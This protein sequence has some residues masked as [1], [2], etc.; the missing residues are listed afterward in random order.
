MT[1][2]VKKILSHLKKRSLRALCRERNVAVPQ[3][4]RKLIKRLAR[5][6]HGDLVSILG[7]LRRSDLIAVAEAVS[8]KDEFDRPVV[9][10]HLRIRQFIEFLLCC[11]TSTAPASLVQT[12][13]DQAKFHSTGS[14]GDV[15]QLNADKLRA[16]AR[17]ACRATVISA[18][19]GCDV[20]KDLLDG[21][22]EVRVL[23]NGLGG[24]RLEE[25]IEELTNLEQELRNSKECAEIKLAFSRGIFHTKLYLFE[26]G[27]ES[28]SW[29]GSANATEAALGG[30]N[31]EILLRLAPAPRTLLDYA[32]CAWANGRTLKDSHPSIDSLTAFFRTGVLYYKPYSTLPMTENPFLPLLEALPHEE[33]R[34]LPQSGFRPPYA[35]EGTAIGAFNIRLVHEESNDA[36]GN[37]E[38]SGSRPKI[39]SY[40]I[41]TCYGYW[42]AAPFVED[43]ECSLDQIG[44]EKDNRLLVLCRWLQGSGR[45]KTIRAYKKYLKNVRRNMNGCKINWEKV[46]KDRDIS[47]DFF[48]STQRIK[49][50][51]D[52]ITENLKEESRRKRLSYAFVSMHVPELWDDVVARQQFEDTF[53]ESLAEQSYKRK[54]PKAAGQ[55][56]KAVGICEETTPEEIRD[57]L[58]EKLTDPNWYNREFAHSDT[59]DRQSATAGR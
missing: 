46:C 36:D 20:L 12:T 32:E 1:L 37:G 35:D 55:L 31:E 26:S 54:W 7:D 30:Y 47:T 40:A 38:E 14:I 57:A 53:F 29:I 5:S 21:C 49:R 27:T 45:K 24:R 25:Q 8:A 42:V 52:T 50:R 9:L 16:D 15:L 2:T 44:N 43:V 48:K 18:Y 3:K 4:R 23:L 22:G 6:Y 19:Y 56:L 41:E 10:K 59:E 58:V 11:D 39:R 17:G 34:K 13:A 51:I 28:I 33:K